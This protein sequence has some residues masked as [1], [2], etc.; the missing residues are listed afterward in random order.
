MEEMSSLPFE[1]FIHPDDLN[2]VLSEYQARLSGEKP[3]NSYTIR[4]ITKAGQVK[5]VF[6]NSALVTWD[7]KP[8]TL[9]M[10]TDITQLK[11]TEQRLLKSEKHFRN[12]MDQ[13]PFPMELL[14]PDGK[15]SQVNPSWYKL[16]GVDEVDAAETIEKYN[17]I[18]DPQLGRLGLTNL[19]K[20]AFSG[21][22]IILPPIIYDASQTVEDFEIENLEGL[23]SPWI[24]C[25]L[26]P[27]KDANGELEFM[28]NTYVDIT[29]LRQA[30][31]NIWESEERFRNLMEFSPLAVA[32]FTPDGKLSRVNTA[33]KKLWG[34]S[35]EE[36][37]QVMSN[38]NFRYDKQIESLG[39]APLVERAFKGE[40]II[41]PPHD[42]EGDRTAADIGLK[43]IEAQSRIIQ[44]HIYSVKDAK[45]EI[46]YVV[47][48]NMDL[49]ELKKSEQEA[50][51]QREALARMDRATRMGQL[52]GSIAHEL[53]QPLTGILGN[54]QAAEMMLKSKKWKREN[55]VEIIADIIADTKRAGD[56]IR[57]LRELYREHKGEYTPVDINSVAEEAIQLLH[58]DFV[59]K[60]VELISELVPSVPLVNGN[61][62]QLQQVLVNLIMNGEQAMSNVAQDDRKLHI[63]T[64]FDEYEVKLWVDDF[65]PGI[66]ED[67]I[68]HI[69][70][71][72]V[73]WKPGGTGMGLAISNSII[74]AHGGRMWAEN[75]SEGGAHV[76]FTLPV[77]KK[78]KK[79]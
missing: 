13:S 45:G 42:Y 22:H 66:E 72:L 5:H 46:D 28:V 27:I 3:A 58:S 34:L 48:I 18:T 6:V 43:D 25:H 44:T 55:Y 49:T 1:K 77:I 36:S 21:E 54:A 19:V 47:T 17:M 75:R 74:E 68:D 50:Q 62:F 59:I 67:K 73:T 37:T 69:F 39:L 40:H 61:R 76:G 20:K 31:K 15:I 65:G 79:K 60:Q 70:E 57:N 51:E 12:L 56:V 53:N 30:E 23:K 71:P 24:Q 64:T 52:T 29:D 63:A 11:D 8:A 7:G 78:D 26:Y 4:I 35:E 2:I 16:W 38:Y 32:I 10:L 33:W 9:A 41:L 14:T